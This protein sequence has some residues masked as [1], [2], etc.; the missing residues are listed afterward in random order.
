MVTSKSSSLKFSIEKGSRFV[1][2][3]P[4]IIKEIFKVISYNDEPK[5][6]SYQVYFKDRYS[7]GE[8]EDSSASGISFNK[9][10]ALMKVL[11]ETIERYSLGG[12]NNKK[13]IYN[14]FS[15][16]KA[17]GKLAIRPEDIISFSDRKRYV[18]NLD[19]KNIHWIEGKSLISSRKKLVPAQLI[20]VPYLYQHSEPLISF[21]ISTGAATGTTS[22]DA[23]Y[24]GICEIVERD[25][26]MIAY[27]NKIPSPR[28]DLFSTNDKSIRDIVNTFKRYKL[29][30]IVLDLTNDLKIPVFAT[31]ILDRTG[32]GPAVSV[33]LKA[34]FDIRETII[35]S[36][37][38]SLM[39]R[40]WIRDKFIYEDPKYKREKE[41]VA[42]EDRAHFWFPVS[43][44]KYLDFWIKNKTLKKINIKGR[45][46]SDNKL[47]KIVKLLKEKKVDIIYVD[48]TDKEIKK[49]GFVVV[50]V[51]IPQ[52]QP[53]YLDERYPYLGGDR[54]YNTPVKMRLLEKPNRQSQLNK[55]PHPFL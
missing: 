50:K 33:G 38:E 23:L 51:I 34:G 55:V 6:Y 30:P 24:R 19:K 3:N 28:I 48:I 52:L 40:S 41:I 11:G 29:E 20:Y 12:N 2:D 44:I 15:E 7:N 45:G 5:L 26:F 22:N 54:L 25:A 39:M 49:Y 1:N 47:E 17:L 9:R 31:I 36:I 27:L 4:A 14:N 35:G 37:E 46:H 42:I 16:L 10:R 13:F 18:Y 21:P 8:N 43:A 32:L 53:L